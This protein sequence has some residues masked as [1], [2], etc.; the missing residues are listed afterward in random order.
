MLL[1]SYV[2]GSNKLPLFPHCGGWDGHQPNSMGD[3]IFLRFYCP[4]W[5]FPVAS[6][7]DELFFGE[8]AVTEGSKV[9]GHA[10]VLSSNLWMWIIGACCQPILRVEHV[11]HADIL[12]TYWHW[13]KMWCNSSTLQSVCLY[14]AH[15]S[16]LTP[17]RN[18][19]TFDAFQQD[20]QRSSSHHFKL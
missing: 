5:T 3:D 20:E 8:R 18:I 19:S 9:V 1:R 17:N 13:S 4:Q 16:Q 6:G 10:G 11:V 12:W 15:L 14:Y 7:T 2:L